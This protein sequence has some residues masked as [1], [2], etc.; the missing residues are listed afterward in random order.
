MPLFSKKPGP[1]LAEGLKPAYDAFQIPVAELRW[2]QN[3]LAWRLRRCITMETHFYD[4]GSRNPEAFEKLKEEEYS[5]NGDGHPDEAIERIYLN[6]HVPIYERLISLLEH[7]SNEIGVWKF[8]GEAEEKFAR[9]G[10]L[11]DM[12]QRVREKKAMEL[13]SDMAENLEEGDDQ[14]DEEEEMQALKTAVQEWNLL[15]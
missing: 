6:M 12:K 1:P 13:L 9:H 14:D 5:V 10:W 7:L 15:D 4:I 8:G 2:G 3:G 11:Q